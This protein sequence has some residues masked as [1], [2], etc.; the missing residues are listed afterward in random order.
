MWKR[1]FEKLITW[2]SFQERLSYLYTQVYMKIQ[3][4]EKS[5][6]K[7]ELNFLRLIFL[8]YLKNALLCVNL[9]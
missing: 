3:S 7:L 5:S 6:C 9:N 1:S 8:V 2:T 4:P